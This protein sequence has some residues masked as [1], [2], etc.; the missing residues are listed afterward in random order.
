MNNKV[1]YRLIGLSVLF[2]FFMIFGFTYWLLKPSSKDEMQKYLIYFNESVS[3]LNLNAPVKYRGISVGKVVDLRINPS[4]I[5]QV[6]ATVEILKTTPIKETTVA[7]LTAQGITG[8]TYINLSL[9]DNSAPLLKAKKGEH[10]PIIKSVPSLFKNVEKSLG[11]LSSQLSD[12]L[13]KANTF[14]DESNRNDTHRVLAHTANILEHVD[15]MLDETTVQH[16]RS[17]ARNL[18]KFSFQLTALT[19]KI[20]QFV[21][22]SIAWEDKMSNSFESIQNTYSDMGGIMDNMAH[23]FA[24]VEKDVKDASLNIVPTIN[25]SLLQMQSTMIEF[26]EVLREYKRSPSDILFKETKQKRGPGEK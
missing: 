2:G 26:D 24:N 23:S 8:L 15:A 4:N 25:E 1:N 7:K 12:V 21:T 18:D 19:P 3:G 6:Q 20:D 10:Y 5:E 9:G 11:E 17:S 22:N 16:L 13:E 14:L